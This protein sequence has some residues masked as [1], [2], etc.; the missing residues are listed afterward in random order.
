MS[1]LKG[2]IIARNGLGDGLVAMILANNLQLNG[3]EVTMYQKGICNQ[4]QAWLPHFK[5]INDYRID[6]VH[7]I[8]E[9]YE[10]IFVVY[11]EV[12]PF[13][14][15]IIDEGKKIDSKKIT[16]INP[17]FSRNVGNQPFY[18]DCMFDPSTSIVDNMELFCRRM[19]HLPK[20]TKYVGFV[21]PEKLKFQKHK[22]RVCFHATSSREG[23]NWSIEKYVKLALQLKNKGYE[24][25]FVMSEEERQR[26]LFLEKEFSCP[27]FKDLGELA[28]FIYESGYF[29]GND[30]GIGHLCSS[31]GIPTITL[32][33][34][35]RISKLWRPSWAEGIVVVPYF[36][37]P[38]ISGFRLRDR[39]WKQFVSVKRVVNAFFQLKEKCEG[40]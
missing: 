24:P 38:N 16:V 4:L 20:T 9:K 36:W 14:Q 3:W 15:K 6:E 29:I 27:L 33:R 1:F 23:K 39:Y 34:G 11:C 21:V 40:R 10:R 12:D 19:L 37:I 25:I 5:I 35:R 28:S 8:L 32:T 2:A 18:E 7:G 13:T 31:L 30:S 22:K 26:Y 17:C